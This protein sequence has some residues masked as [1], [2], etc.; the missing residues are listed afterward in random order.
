[1][2]A[3]QTKWGMIKHNVVKCVKYYGI[4]MALSKLGTSIKRCFPNGIRIIQIK[5]PQKSKICF[6][7]LLVHIEG[8]S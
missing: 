7:T 5:A 6:H 2:K 8:S 3:F 1:M 4:I